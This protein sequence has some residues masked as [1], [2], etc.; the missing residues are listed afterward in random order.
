MELTCNIHIQVTL[1]QVKN[2][3]SHETGG[4]VTQTAKDVCVEGI[5]CTSQEMNPDSPVTQP[6]DSRNRVILLPESLP[7]YVKKINLRPKIKHTGLKNILSNSKTS[8]QNS[9]T[10]LQLPSECSHNS[11]SGSF[12]LNV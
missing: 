3:H 9:A 1:S 5:P 6:T 10:Y 11:N 7:I 8:K 12:K 4:W 2:I